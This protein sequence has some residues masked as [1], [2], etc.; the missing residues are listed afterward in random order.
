MRITA[1]LPRIAITGGT[2]VVFEYANRLKKRGHEVNIVYPLVPLII[3]PKFD[4]KGLARQGSETIRNLKIGNRVDWLDFKANLVRVPILDPRYVKSIERLIPDA[5]IVM[6]TSWETAYPV[7]RLS[8]KKGEKFYLI[9]HYEIWN[10]WNSDRCWGKVQETER[11][12]DKM[13]VAMAD[14]IPDDAIMKKEKEIVD[15]TYKLPLRKIVESSWLEEVME[16]KFGEHVED[17]IGVAINFDQIYKEKEGFGCHEP[18]RVG[19]LYRREKWK[20]MKDGLKALWIVKRKHPDVQIVLFG[21]EPI[22][23]DRGIIDK[24]SNIEFHRLPY[25]ERLRKIY[26]SLDIFVCPSWVEGCQLPPLETMACGC[27]VVATNVGGVPDYAING[28]TILA[29]PPRDPEALARNIIVLLED[30]DRRK[31][32]A[33]NGYNHVKQFT[34]EKATDRLENIFKKY[35]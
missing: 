30:E 9:Q 28:K 12:Q 35:I 15:K 4:S 26:N 1:V 16:K 17:V 3:R 32:L 22:P 11:N 2:K 29:S 8:S 23:D 7:S 20:G 21:E 10:V 25:K 27:A 34:W 19:I 14:V 6:A 24:L 13:C 31:R 5:D 18:K 33:E